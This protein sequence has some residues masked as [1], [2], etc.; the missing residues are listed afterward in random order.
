M[1]TAAALD[2]AGIADAFADAFAGPAADPADRARL[3]AG[4]DEPVFLPAGRGRPVGEVV[5]ARGLAQSCLH[6]AAHWLRAGRARRRL[7][8]YGYWYLPDGRDAE[9]QARFERLEAEVQALEWILSAVAGVPFAISCDNLA[10]P[11]P[12]PDFRAA[13][14]AAARRRLAVG[15][16]GR[17]ARLVQALRARSGLPLPAPPEDPEAAVRAAALGS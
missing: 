13:I 5:W 2:P 6:E 9:A 16:D 10:R 1:S 12:S 15:L 11:E 17:C 4:G 7:V 3:V 8:D 14:A